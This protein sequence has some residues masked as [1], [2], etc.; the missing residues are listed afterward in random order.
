VLSDALGGFWVAL[1]IGI[2]TAGVAALIASL[3]STWPWV[4]AAGLFPPVAYA[5]MR[6]GLFLWNLWAYRHG[7]HQDPGWELEALMGANFI[8]LTMTRTANADVVPS[9][10]VVVEVQVRKPDGT[11]EIIPD[12]RIHPNRS[13]DGRQLLW[14]QFGGDRSSVP[15]DYELRWYQFKG[16]RAYELASGCFPA[17]APS[18]ESV[19]A[20][21]CDG[22]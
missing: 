11:V 9:D 12:M 10:G 3:G 17:L 18:Q 1:V 16:K 14:T 13:I 20:V 8:N 6:L 19:T 15:G 5:L 21:R 22:R 7:G 2:L 4:L